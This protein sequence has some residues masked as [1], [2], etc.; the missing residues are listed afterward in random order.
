MSHPPAALLAGAVLAGAVLAGAVL[1][2]AVLAGAVLA[3]APGQAS[4]AA[5]TSALPL[6]GRVVAIDPGHQLGNSRFP[7]QVDRRV[8]VG[9]W[10]PCNSTGTATN[11]GFPEATFTWWVSRRLAVRLEA[12]GATVRMTRTTNSRDD[13]GPC[14]DARGRFGA[15]VGADLEVSV[16]GDGAA[17]G[18]HGF[19]VIRPGARPG[20]TDD[21]AGRSS[22][23]AGH[24]RAG[25]LGVGFGASTAYGGDGLDTRRDLG[26]LTMADVPTVMVE[27]GNM[28]NA[29]DARCMTSASC[30]D[31]YARGLA[32]GVL[33]Y[34]SR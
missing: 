16:H 8:W 13:W 19:F 10:K 14:V 11:G 21:I 26:T 34:L 15:E 6:A 2:G 1:A 7:A 23:L 27:L 9:L 25:L 4:P 29:G 28:R 32:D 24:V 17:A 22:V 5:A 12:L 30:R 33:A 18:T 3:G 31:R 20:Y